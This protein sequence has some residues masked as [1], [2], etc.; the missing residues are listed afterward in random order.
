M[1]KTYLLSLATILA[2][3][4]VSIQA[5]DIEQN[6]PAATDAFTVDVN[7]V[8]VMRVHGDGNVGVGVSTPTNTLDVNGTTRVRDLAGYQNTDT[9]VSSS[10]TGVLRNSGVTVQSLLD[11]IA[12]LQTAVDSIDTDGDGLSNVDEATAGTNPLMPDTDGD[13]VN[14]GQEVIDGTDPLDPASFIV[15]PPDPLPGDIVLSGGQVVFLASLADTD[16]TPYT[17]P[18]GPATLDTNVA[19]DGTADTAVDIQGDLNTTGKIVGIPYTVTTN[20]VTLPAF[21]QTITIPANVTED[22]ISRDVIL[23]YPE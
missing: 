23:S 14:D 11:A 18:T 10:A 9:I 17:A 3:G 4:G 19:S 1:K 6:L 22:G 21:T 5:G 8:E 13:G 7:S 20:P 15:P 16:Y 2:L 12:N